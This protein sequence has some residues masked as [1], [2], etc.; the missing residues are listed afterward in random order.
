MKFYEK[1]IILRKKTL[2][3]QEALAEKLNVTR[4]TI[5]KWELGQSKPDM[6][7]LIEMSKLF[8]VNI[9]VLT[10][11]E[12]SIDDI[13]QESNDKNTKQKNT[14]NRKFILY[15]L[16][17][18]LIVSVVTLAIRIGNDRKK[19]ESGFL[20]LFN[21]VF[22][23]IEETKNEI[24]VDSFNI[25]LKNETTSGFLLLSDIDEIIDS[26]KTNKEHLIE[27]VFDGTSYGTEPEKIREIKDKIIDSSDSKYDVSLDYDKKGYV[28]KVTITTKET[29]STSS[30][31]R[32]FEFNSG[33]IY[34]SSVR[35]LLDD[36]IKSNNKHKDHLVEVV[37]QGTSYGT[38]A[39][40][41]RNAKTIIGTNSFK[42]N[43]HGFIEY[44]VSLEYDDKG[45]V[46][47]ITI[48]KL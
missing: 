45:Y 37:Y 23:G 48:E 20:N 38:D 4:Q 7:K 5:S 12:L 9:D 16:I 1:L 41:I 36:V 14:G 8:N 31:N 2:L 43:G 30:F 17:V 18:I 39:E 46:I 33:T 11:D 22:N 3:S 10:N 34:N 44:E 15:I 25:F 29:I 40:G 21:S 42:E 32:S 28:N 19:K 47:K 27:V 6:D 26:N 35:N 13:K 24:S